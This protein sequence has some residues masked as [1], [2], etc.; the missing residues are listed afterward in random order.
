MQ[1]KILL[2]ANVPLEAKHLAYRLKEI[3]RPSA[4]S[5]S[6]AHLS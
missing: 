6:R 1:V 2:L 3:V 5:C 4:L